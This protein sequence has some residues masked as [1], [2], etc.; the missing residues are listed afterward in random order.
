MS[1]KVLLI[2]DE[3][4]LR[5]MIRIYLNARGMKVVEASNGERAKQI[6]VQEKFDVIVLDIMMPVMD[7]FTFLEQYAGTAPI[8]VLSAKSQID[9]KL[10]GFQYGIDDYLTKPFDLRELVARLQVLACRSGDSQRNVD[11]PQKFIL[12]RESYT[13]I[14]NGNEVS[15]TPK[16]FEILDV[17]SRRPERVFKRDEILIQIWGYEHDGDERVVDT[18]VKNIRDKCK[19]AGLSDFPI[20]TVWGIGYKFGGQQT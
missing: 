3:T 18:H 2:E 1:L 20:L 17:L 6:L 14:V 8:L 5:N 19:K 11:D 16:E 10:R 9:D 12:N 4:K 15:L 13:V 7:G